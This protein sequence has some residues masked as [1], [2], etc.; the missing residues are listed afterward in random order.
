MKGNTMRLIIPT[1]ALLLLF[2]SCSSNDDKFITKQFKLAE[3]GNY[4]AKYELWK[5]YSKGI[6]GI[7]KDKQKADELI[8]ELT[9]D[10]YMAKFMPVGDFNPKKPNELLK[11]FN[12]NSYLRS[13]KESI[14]GASFFRTE[15][16]NNKL[17]GSFLT[18]Y[19]EK[20]KEDIE[21]NPDLMLIS[22]KKINPQM[23]IDYE[24][25]IQ[26]SID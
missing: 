26:E 8:A 25:R 7:T 10:V 5:A 18:A 24:S 9:K 2:L 20:I 17:A 11:N 16:I 4:W 12:D 15:V 6:Y 1:L 19:P 3:K 14:G 13:E 23:F 22:I 21:D